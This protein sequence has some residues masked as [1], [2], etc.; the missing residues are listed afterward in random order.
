MP[1][2]S[3]AA[4]EHAIL[5]EITVPLATIPDDPVAV[6]NTDFPVALRGY[7]RVAVDE[8]VRQTSQLVAELQSTR[9]PD[10]AIRRALERLGEQISGI[11]QRA[12]DT[13]EQ[14]TTQSRGDAEDRVEAARQEAANI[15]A[16][17]EQRVRDL[18]A[19]TDRI[20]AERHRIVDDTRELA[21]QL[22]AL[23][24]PAADRFP[25]AEEPELGSPVYDDATATAAEPSEEDRADETA[26]REPDENDVT[27]VFPVSEEDEDDQREP[28]DDGDETAAFDPPQFDDEPRVEARQDGD[29]AS[30]PPSTPGGTRGSARK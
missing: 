18:D 4:S 2:Q 21:R 13:A 16:G 8:Y 7:D 29:D 19:E 23:A 17:A 5:Q 3:S 9:S 24:E 20:W 22:L 10:A 11:L 6:V 14:I 27:A 25:A 1:D 28:Q 12:H 26:E 30:F 15:V